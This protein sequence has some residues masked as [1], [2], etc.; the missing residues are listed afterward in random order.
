MAHAVLAPSSAEK[1]MNCPPS[2]RL[3]ATMP[4]TSGIAA[5]EGTVAH[6]LCELLL[7]REIGLIEID[8]YKKELTR[9][10]SAVYFNGNIVYLWP[11]ELGADPEELYSEAMFDHA[12][13]YV[14]MVM[15]HFAE[16]KQLDPHAEIYTE[17]RFDLTQYIPEGSGT[18]DT[19]IVSYQILW[20]HDLKY[21]KGV[22]V[23]SDNNR[24]LML[25]ALGAYLEFYWMYNFK[26][27]RMTIFQPR[28]DNT[29]TAVITTEE[30]LH[31]AETE[32]KEIAA[33]AFEGKGEF[34]PGK[35]CTAYFCAV[36]ATCRAHK[37]YNMQVAEELFKEP[38][39]LT[40]EEI[41]QVLDRKKQLENWLTAVNDY[42]QGAALLGTEFPGMKLVKGR[43]N[44]R[45][46]NPKE[47][48]S[49]LTA[50]GYDLEEIANV[51]PLGLGEME[52]TIGKLLFGEILAPLIDKPE[53]KPTLVHETDKRPAISSADEAEKLF[54]DS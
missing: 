30:L 46:R 50:L 2:A 26:E 23:S 31:W 24:Q 32:L 19:P 47:V 12:T 4:D 39:L 51:K 15:Q 22:P 52:K 43:S 7:K 5:A 6:E 13:D 42:A 44:R 1:W 38:A 48:I 40:P 25:Y 16:L 29:S 45:Y 8:A 9:I 37:D 49:A 53:G 54:A 17:K 36:R 27:I 35:H 28:I 18:C 33:L 34:K 21:G 3:E 41:V 20:I 11:E 14:Y 10:K